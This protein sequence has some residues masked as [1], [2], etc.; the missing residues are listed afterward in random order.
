MGVI[1]QVMS[2]K[3]GGNVERVRGEV[4]GGNVAG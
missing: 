4:S 3:G 2:S 1:S